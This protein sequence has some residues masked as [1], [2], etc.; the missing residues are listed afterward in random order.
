VRLTAENRR[1]HN[2]V[3]GH[4]LRVNSTIKRINRRMSSQ[5]TNKKEIPKSPGYLE[6]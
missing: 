5:V 1:L 6:K 3:I 4:E 2:T